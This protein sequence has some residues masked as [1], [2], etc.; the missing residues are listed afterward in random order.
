MTS[1]FSGNGIPFEGHL[2]NPQ[3][4]KGGVVTLVSQPYYCR[5]GCS[6]PETRAKASL[7]FGGSGGSTGHVT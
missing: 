7:D 3:Y 5:I 1:E 4:S 2:K 6:D